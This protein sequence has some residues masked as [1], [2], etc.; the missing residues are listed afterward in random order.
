MTKSGK[1][2]NRRLPNILMARAK[3]PKVVKVA[4]IP[5]AP[6]NTCLRVKTSDSV[7]ANIT[8]L[9]T[10]HIM[11]YKVTKRINQGICARQLPNSVTIRIIGC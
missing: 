5:A 6:P 10:T 1:R 2:K 9:Y 4:A 3:L 11:Q 7:N 8:Q